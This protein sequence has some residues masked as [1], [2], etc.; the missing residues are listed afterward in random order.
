MKPGAGDDPF[1]EDNSE[2][3]EE[4]EPE[5]VNNPA[6]TGPEVE[7]SPEESASSSAQATG[8]TEQ[9][10]KLP[11]KYRRD[12]VKENRMQQPMFIQNKTKEMID[13]TLDAVEEEFDE[14]IYKTDIVEAM[15][16]A[17][18]ENTT[19][20]AVLRRWGYGMKNEQQKSD[21]TSK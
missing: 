12:S 18:G 8:E 15:I 21:T 10:T 3:K 20:V 17:G 5:S 16:I 11:Y 2:E 7:N 14:D 19:P 9:L 13:E 1:A 4:D 6:A